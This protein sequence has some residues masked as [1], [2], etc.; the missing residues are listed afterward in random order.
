MKID[1]DTPNLP[2]LKN[3]AVDSAAV[4]ANPTRAAGSAL[5]PSSDQLKLSPDMAIARDAITQAA[6]L[7]DIRQDRVDQVRKL[8]EQGDVGRDPGRLADA[9][10]TSLIDQPVDKQE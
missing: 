1:R 7:P 2:P 10:I 5:A 9:I 8:L 3:D 4:D 6:T